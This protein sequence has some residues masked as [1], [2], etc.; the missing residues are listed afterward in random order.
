VPEF[1]TCGAQL[2]PDARFCHKCAKPQYDD[3]AFHQEIEA[4]APLPPPIP[5]APNINFHNRV[6]VRAGFVAAVLGLMLSMIPLPFVEVRT[7][8]TLVAAGVLAAYLYRRGSG[9]TLTVGGGARVGWITGIFVFAMALIL[10]IAAFL[11][12]S[13][14][15]SKFIETVRSQMPSNQADALNKALNDPA[16]LVAGILFSLIPLTALPILGGALCAKLLEKE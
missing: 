14:S 11:I 10:V 8:V 16:S 6:A 4:A 3:P 15:D 7:L 12:I 5:V 2:P 9:Q 1:C 13:S